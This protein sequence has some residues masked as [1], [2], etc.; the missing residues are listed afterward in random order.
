MVALPQGG[1]LSVSATYP[2]YVAEVEVQL[3]EAD[4]RWPPYLTLED[5]ERAIVQ[6]IVERVTV[7]KDEIEITLCCLPRPPEPPG[8][9]PLQDAGNSCTNP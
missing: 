1:K 5:A 4:E 2:E 6:A 9:P 3:I 7:G 8:P